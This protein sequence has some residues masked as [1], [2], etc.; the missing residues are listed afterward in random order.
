V[1]TV[2]AV[3]VAL[4]AGGIWWGFF[5]DSHSS[6]DCAPVRELLTFNKS[7]VDALNAKTHIPA[8][9]SHEA[10]TG[11]S[12]LDYRAW[13]YGIGDRAEKVTAAG[14]SDRARDVAHTVDRLVEAKIDFDA[15]EKRTAP[16]AE[17][18]AVAMVVSAFNDQY[19]AQIAGLAKECPE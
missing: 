12:D 14:L 9:G 19:E 4:I 7:Q 15:Q 18:P 16:G 17:Q 13:S 2:V 5:R 3:A 10:A 11:P 1:G 8:E 6:A